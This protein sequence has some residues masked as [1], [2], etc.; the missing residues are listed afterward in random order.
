M[1][2]WFGGGANCFADG[3]SGIGNVGF[4]CNGKGGGDVVSDGVA[5][6]ELSSLSG[7]VLKGDSLRCCSEIAEFGV[8]ARVVPTVR[9][10]FGASGLAALL[11]AGGNAFVSCSL[12]I[13]PVERPALR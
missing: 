6:G 8:V 9:S 5:S 11:I 1:V 12:P 2:R 10:L 4:D 3:D 13:L 7:G